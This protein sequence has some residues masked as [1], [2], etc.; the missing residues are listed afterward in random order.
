MVIHAYLFL[1]S[2]IPFLSPIPLH[3]LFF[4]LLWNGRITVYRIWTG[5]CFDMEEFKVYS[6]SSSRATFSFPFT[7]FIFFSSFQDGGFHGDGIPFTLWI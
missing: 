7:L 5:E 4:S 2:H 1:S 6:S 3:P